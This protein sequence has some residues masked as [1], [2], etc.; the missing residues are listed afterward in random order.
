[1]VGDRKR[2]SNLVLIGKVVY[3]RVIGI[4]PGTNVT[5][6]AIVEKGRSGGMEYIG[7][8]EVKLARGAPLSERLLEISECLNSVIAE[9]GPT[10]CAIEEVF[11]AKNV[12]SAL[13][14]GHGRGVALLSAAKA[15]IDVYEYSAS[16]IKQAVV[17]SGRGTKDQVQ[18]MVRI[19]LKLQRPLG[20]DASD[21]IAV[22]ICHLNHYNPRLAR[23]GGLAARV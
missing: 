7:G 16:T 15:G 11:F 1:M 19:L 5:G 12:K 23:A 2:R 4:D 22:A 20:A 13:T 8:G 17:G 21:A 14:L 10:H 6:F 18:K 9:Y 3:M